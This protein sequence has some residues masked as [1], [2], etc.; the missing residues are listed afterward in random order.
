[1]QFQVIAQHN[2]VTYMIKNYQ[3]VA[4]HSMTVIQTQEQMNRVAETQMS[5]SPNLSL[6]M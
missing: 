1:M 6:V 4:S 2:V 5:Q 3:A